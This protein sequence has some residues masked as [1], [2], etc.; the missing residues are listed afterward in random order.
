MFQFFW[1]FTGPYLMGMVS[2]ND[3]SGR[4]SML[5]PAATTSGFSFGPIIAGLMMTGESLLPANHVSV[6]CIT[7]A[8]VLFIILVLQQRSST[9][10]ATVA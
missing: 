4:L 5:M 10:P 9:T 1:N 7:L 3:R 6:S 2:G 8:L